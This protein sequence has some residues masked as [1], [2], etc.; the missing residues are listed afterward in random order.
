MEQTGN[1]YIEVVRNL[2]NQ[3]VF[4]NYVPAHT[5]RCM[6]LDAPIV[7]EKKVMR[8][9]QEITVPT[10]IR[11]RRYAQMIGAIWIYFRQFGSFRHLNYETSFWDAA[12]PPVPVNKRGDTEII[13]L[14]VREKNAP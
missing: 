2:E 14:K 3:I 7:V 11:E 5:I 8:D 9:G 1:G 4:L 6:R 10:L 13:H 12:E